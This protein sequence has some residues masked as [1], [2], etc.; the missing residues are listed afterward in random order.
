MWRARARG[1]HGWRGRW[2]ICATTGL[3][4]VWNKHTRDQR[5]DDHRGGARRAILPQGRRAAGLTMLAADER[6]SHHRI[7]KHPSVCSQQKPALGLTQLSRRDED[8]SWK[9]DAGLECLW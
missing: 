3:G 9:S 7:T 1:E 5:A 6:T 8:S 4:A 2:E